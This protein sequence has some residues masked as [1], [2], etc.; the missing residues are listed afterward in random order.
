M[1]LVLLTMSFG[2]C[3]AVSCHLPVNQMCISGVVAWYFLFLCLPSLGGHVT[4][5]VPL[6]W[7]EQVCMWRA[8]VHVCVHLRPYMC[9]H[10]YM[11]VS[12]FLWNTQP[13][14]SKNL[15]DSFIM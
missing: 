14:Y 2:F 5:R 3:V 4:L 9:A 15:R 8:Y 6:D 7:S 10:A 12:M 13:I 11:C 1:M